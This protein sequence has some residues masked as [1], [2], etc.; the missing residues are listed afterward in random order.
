M[1]RKELSVCLNAPSETLQQES[2][3]KMS[4]ELA[5][6]NLSLLDKEFHALGVPIQLGETVFNEIKELTSDEYILPFDMKVGSLI[7]KGGVHLE[8]N[9]QG[10]MYTTSFYRFVVVNLPL[11]MEN[12][13]FCTPLWMVTVEEAVNLIQGRYIY[14]K[15]DVDPL[16]EGYWVYLAQRELIAGF[17]Q[18][19][20]VRI[21]FDVRRY[22][23][24]TGI[25]SWLGLAGWTKL[26][27]DLEKGY[28]CDLTLGSGK[29]MRAVKVE[30]DPLWQRLKVTNGKGVEVGL[31]D[32]SDSGKIYRGRGMERRKDQNGSKTG[33][34]QGV[35]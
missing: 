28:L 6:L 23:T 7:I 14:R 25:G 4:E 11:F 1:K 35:S 27:H 19:V 3:K 21:G 30:A 2:H 34:K 33:V 31:E 20:F 22:L 18:P 17:R 24:E 26:V 12:A 13:F 5:Y 16:G 29:G 8:A 32:G 15:P 10:G 9:G